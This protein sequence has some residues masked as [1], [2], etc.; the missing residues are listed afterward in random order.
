MWE[1]WGVVVEHFSVGIDPGREIA[2]PAEHKS[3]RPHLFVVVVV[4]VVVVCC[5]FV[6]KNPE[7]W[8]YMEQF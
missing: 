3:V 4:V 5:L 2:Y 7:E 8:R 1:L 6:T